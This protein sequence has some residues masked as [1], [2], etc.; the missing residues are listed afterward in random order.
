M[1]PPINIPAPNRPNTADNSILFANV[2]KIRVICSE[3][4]GQNCL[5]NS[6]LISL[7]DV[8]LRIH[9]YDLTRRKSLHLLMDSWLSQIYIL[10]D[11]V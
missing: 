9:R 2:S 6:Y 11:C 5:G 4:A 3:D 8:S 1:E 7:K 10:Q